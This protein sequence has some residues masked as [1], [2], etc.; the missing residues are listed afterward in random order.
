MKTSFGFQEK[1]FVGNLRQIALF[2]AVAASLAQFIRFIFVSLSRISYP[3]SLEW[4][5]G[6]S[7][8]QV[9]RILVGQPLYVRPSFEFI[10]QIYPPVYF[11][12][13][14]L[15]SKV[16]G[17]SFFP[18]RLVSVLATIGTLFLIYTLVYKQ[19]GSQ[20]G[21]ILASGLFCATFELS[22]HWFDIARVDSLALTLLLLSAY[23]LLQDKPNASILGGIFLVLSILTK[24][25][26]LIVAGIFL[27][28]CVLPPRKNSL[29]F[30]GTAS[31]G[32]AGGTLLLDWLH[33]GW[34]SY[35]IFHLPGRHRVIPNIVK[36]V[37]S[38]NEILLIEI[39]KPVLFATAIGLLYLLR[40]PGKQLENHTD[41]QE[42][43][44]EVNMNWSQ[45][46]VWLVLFV[47]GF[48]SI[49]SFWYLASLPS[50]AER[51]VIGTYSFARLILMSGPILMAL[52]MLF[53]AN[54]MRTNNALPG[55]IADSLF[56][57]GRTFPRMLLGCVLL[58]F[59]VN[60]L[61]VSFRPDFY[62]RVGTAYLQRISPYVVGPIILLV[63]LG[64]LWRLLWRSNR[65]ETWFFLLLG[66]GMVATSW[67]GRLNP[68]GYLNVFMPGFAGLSILFGLGVGTILKG[69]PR[70]TSIDGNILGILVL[71]LS[72]AQ[73]IL[74]LSPPDSQIPTRADVDAGL[75]LVT[76]I[77]VCP[78]NVYIPFHTYL[79]ALAGK[80]G[81]AGVVEMGEL[82]GSFGGRPDPLWDEVL[83]QIQES[84]EKQT[85]TAVIQDNQV[86]REAIPPGYIE[87]DPV[88]VNEFVFWPVTGRKIRPEI[89]YRPVDE[90]ECLIIVE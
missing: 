41:S 43:K 26:M 81:Y 22:G 54:R 29:F 56:G 80:D 78:G 70:K 12:L 23:F 2:L 51:A 4:M 13:S 86:F 61:L 11:Y 10:P 89:I 88:F 1:R 30:L 55:R 82:K 76:Q 31:L 65:L 64:V 52:L 38:V 58:A 66:F 83:V 33:E 39:V 60:T 59:V 17:N 20:T 32:F 67:L 79:S 73:M 77:E 72:S 75:K 15:L 71:L 42:G 3:F 7:F 19:S 21:G 44:F 24:Q 37:A 87:T 47:A 63:V 14:A 68:G 9:S 50:D 49:G 62:D 90:G 36:L 27:I 48:L 6:G 45:R 35:Y 18:L 28:Y 8:V 74:L 69:L 25:T 16:L 40:Y 34:Y 53:L 84:F 5:E 85:F 46:A 57:D